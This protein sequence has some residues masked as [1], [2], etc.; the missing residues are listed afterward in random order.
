MAK[1]KECAQDGEIA[2]FLNM[3][4]PEVRPIV[5]ELRELVSAAAPT[6]TE[7]VV[8]GSLSYHLAILGGR[9]KGA[10]CQI[11]PRGGRVEVA[12]IHGALLPDPRHLLRGGGKS[13]RVFRVKDLGG[14]TQHALA[15]LIRSAV[16]NRPDTVV[17]S[18]ASVAGRRTR[19]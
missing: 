12:F 5:Q 3:L 14:T 16:R 15:R 10:V 13:K 6:A 17:T 11:C 2:A 4:S 1:P 19:G 9:V 8:W 7:T 18:P